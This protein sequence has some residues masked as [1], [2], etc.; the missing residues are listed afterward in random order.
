MEM[1]FIKS[2]ELNGLNTNGCSDIIGD[3]F[4]V[5]IIASALSLM[6]IHIFVE[7]S[8]HISMYL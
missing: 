7:V 3:I 2:N 4:N 5:D 6:I 1:R 8:L